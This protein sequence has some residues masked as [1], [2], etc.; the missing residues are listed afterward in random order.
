MVKSLIKRLLFYTR[1]LIQFVKKGGVVYINVANLAPNARFINKRVFITGGGSGFGLEMAKEFHAEGADV[2]ICGR[3]FHK[4]ELS[5]NTIGKN[6]I[7]PEQLDISDV[8]LIPQKMKNIIDKYGNIDIFINNAG[9]GQAT[10]T[11]EDWDR[12]IDIN[13]KGTRFMM[14]YEIQHWLENKIQGRMINITSVGGLVGGSDPYCVSKWGIACLSD[15]LAKSYAHYGITINC[16][17]PGEAVTP[18]NPHLCDIKPTDNQIN[19]KQPNRRFTR[20]EDVA[21]LALFLA[22]DVASS[23]TGQHIAV[24][25]GW[26]IHS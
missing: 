9:V 4:L 15:G 23:I 7:H 6:R 16:I 21:S 2:I 19:W 20:V 10:Y 17:A 3:D 24:D 11:L 25:G 14:H 13:L 1:N 22:S 8:E 26:T 12:I 5:A 18:I